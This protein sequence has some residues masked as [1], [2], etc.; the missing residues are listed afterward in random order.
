MCSKEELSVEFHGNDQFYSIP[1]IDDA[2]GYTYIRKNRQMHSEAKLGLESY[3]NVQVYS[4]QQYQTWL[5]QVSSR[6]Y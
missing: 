2:M 3:G 4:R 5:A 6:D 1:K